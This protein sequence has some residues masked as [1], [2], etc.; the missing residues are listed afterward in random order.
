[1]YYIDISR[2]VSIH[3]SKAFVKYHDVIDTFECIDVGK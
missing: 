2:F 1:V 3:V